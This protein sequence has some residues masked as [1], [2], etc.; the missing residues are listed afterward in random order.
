MAI[1]MRRPNYR[2]LREIYDTQGKASLERYMQE[3]FRDKAMHHSEFSLRE[4]AEDTVDNG[5]EW[6]EAMKPG[7][8]HVLYEAGQVNSSAF[9][10]ITGQIYYNAVLEAY[11][12]ED[13]KFSQLIPTIN[14]KI[15]DGEK[16]AGLTRIG[17]EAEIVDEAA[18]YPLVGFGEDWVRTPA[19]IKRG[20]ICAVTAEA[21]TADTTGQ[22]LGHARE[23]GYWL[24]VN[25]EKRAIDT[26]IDENTTVGRLNWRDT[27]YATYQAATPWINIQATN[28][29]VDWTDVENIKILFSNMTDPWTGEPIVIGRTGLKLIC[30]DQLEFTALRIRN[31]TEITVVTPGY[32]T[33]GNPTETRVANPVQG[34][35][36]VVS[37]ALLA[38]RLGIDTSWFFGK[39]ERAFRYMSVW[40]MAVTQ[41]PPNSEADFERDVVF[42]MRARERGAFTTFNPRYMAKA[43]VA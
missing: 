40:D 43:T 39:P 36:D 14:T 1:G 20:L 7:K 8:S 24:G 27:S 19:T 30:T 38:A 6:V 9:S 31:A 17:D 26:I 28:A 15:K 11:Q 42:R 35:F 41:A 37:S 3:A 33:S 4:L 13:F 32:T 2:M 18:P 23:V 29:L 22:I 5:R 34:M 21:I 16:I 25:K 10:S 12:D